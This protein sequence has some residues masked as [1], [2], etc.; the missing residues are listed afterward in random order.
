M[1]IERL[2][3]ASRPG[4]TRSPTTESSSRCRRA[5]RS[6]AKP[7]AGS[8]GSNATGTSYRQRPWPAPWRRTWR[9]EPR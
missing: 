1:E 9:S 2:T 4:S 6:C 8:R 5:A 7:T 3:R